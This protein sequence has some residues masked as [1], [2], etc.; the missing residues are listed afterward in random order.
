MAD[1]QP[2][3]KGSKRK[4]MIILIAVGGLLLLVIGFGGMRYLSKHSAKKS[5]G[6]TTQHAPVYFKLKTMVVNFQ[7]PTVARFLQVGIDVMTHDPKLIEKLKTNLPAI[8][9][10][11]IIL[12][13]GQHYQGISTPVGKEKLRKEVLQAI[14]SELHKDGATGKVDQVYFTSFVMQ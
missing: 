4:K 14:N 6:T 13:S 11:L 12:L 7:N 3:E 9:N 10:R 8:R 5:G 2:K 1:Q